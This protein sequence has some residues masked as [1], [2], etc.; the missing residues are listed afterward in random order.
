M[1]RDFSRFD[2][3]RRF[4]RKSDLQAAYDDAY[5]RWVQATI[6]G[7][8]EAAALAEGECGRLARMGERRYK[9]GWERPAP[10]WRRYVKPS[11]HES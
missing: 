4:R 5:F 3:E 9:G 6:E 7:D 8:V 11:D 1:S 2:R 10:D